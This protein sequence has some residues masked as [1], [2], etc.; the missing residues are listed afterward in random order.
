M[1]T[2]EINAIVR[3]RRPFA[4]KDKFVRAV[5]AHHVATSFAQDAWRYPRLWPALELSQ[6]KV[7]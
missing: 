5:A 4:L 2:E 3:V 7:I 6:F 1:R